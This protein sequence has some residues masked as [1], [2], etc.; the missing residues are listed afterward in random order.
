MG[1]VDSIVGF[2]IVDCSI[3]GMILGSVMVFLSGEG[4]PVL[5]SHP[6]SQPTNTKA[7]TAMAAVIPPMQPPSQLDPSGGVTGSVS[8]PSGDSGGGGLGDGSEGEGRGGLCGGSGGDAG[9]GGGGFEGGALVSTTV[10]VGAVTTRPVRLVT[11]AARV[12]EIVLALT[13]P[14]WACTALLW[15][16]RVA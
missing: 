4:H 10:I 9:G 1:S 16:C 6:L 8:E 13:L 15:F 5:A 12:V 3:L 14:A 11:A 2:S 7:S